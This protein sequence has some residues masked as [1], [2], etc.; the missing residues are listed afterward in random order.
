MMVKIKRSNKMAHQMDDIVLSQVHEVLVEAGFDG[1]AETMT[2]LLKRSDNAMAFHRP[3][4]AWRISPF[5]S[6]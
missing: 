3:R 2:L 4:S 6:R 5:D 1:L